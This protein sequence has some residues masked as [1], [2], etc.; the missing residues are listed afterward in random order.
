MSKPMIRLDNTSLNELVVAYKE[1]NSINDHLNSIYGSNWGDLSPLGGIWSDL[2]EII[3]L[4]VGED[5]A[6]EF[7]RNTKTEPIQSIIRGGNEMSIR[8]LIQTL[9]NVLNLIKGFETGYTTSND[10]QMLIEN[11]GSVFKITIEKVGEGKVE[12]FIKTEI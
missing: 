2:R 5:E 8:K 10:S 7:I 4:H 6:E 12:D 1:I 3:E 11:E 9:H